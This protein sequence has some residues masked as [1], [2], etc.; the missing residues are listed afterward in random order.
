MVAGRITPWEFA[1]VARD[2]F[3]RPNRNL[4]KTK[5]LDREICE[6]LIGC[7]FVVCS[8]LWNMIQPHTQQKFHGS[9]PMHLLWALLFLKCYCTLPILSRIAGTSDR[10]F[11]NWNWLFVEAIHDLQNRV[12]SLQNDND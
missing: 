7:S 3:G 4:N 9:H 1:A 10:E 11:S 6:S 5:E 12:V 8:E 2:V